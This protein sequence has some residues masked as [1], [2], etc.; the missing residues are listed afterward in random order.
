MLCCSLSKEKRF[1][2]AFEV[3]NNVGKSQVRWQAV[4]QMQ[5]CCR[6]TP[7]TVAVV[8]SWNNAFLVLEER[9]W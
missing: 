5:S 6:K 2:L 1:Q 7:V 4:P 3:V 8:C 9:S